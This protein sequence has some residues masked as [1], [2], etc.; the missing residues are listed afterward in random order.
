MAVIFQILCVL[1]LDVHEVLQELGQL[2]GVL[3]NVKL[4][5]EPWGI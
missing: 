4:S 5:C 3:L 2:K 1:S